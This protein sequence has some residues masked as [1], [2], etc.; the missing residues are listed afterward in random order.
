MKEVL[1]PV[2]RRLGIIFAS[3][4]YPGLRSP[5]VTSGTLPVTPALEWSQGTRETLERAQP[6]S[7]W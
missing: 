3:R 1:R 7:W 4:F 6:L 2:N 5:L